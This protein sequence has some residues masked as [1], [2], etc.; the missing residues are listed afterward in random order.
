MTRLIVR[1]GQHTPFE[2]PPK[3]LPRIKGGHIQN[4][5]R[6]CKGLEPASAPFAYAAPLTEICL[7][8]NLAKRMD[9]R[10][11]W[12]AASMQVTNLPDANRYVKTPYRSGWSLGA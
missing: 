7:L 4:W 12:D 3:T 8:G 5:V 6:A 10:L 1:L 2:R 11:T 9:A